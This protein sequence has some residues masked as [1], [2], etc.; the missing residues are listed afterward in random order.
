[1]DV[2]VDEAAAVGRRQR[3]VA[4]AARRLAVLALAGRQ[5]APL[6]AVGRQADDLE[7]AVGVGRV[8]PA[9]VGHRR[10]APLAHSSPPPAT[11]RSSPVSTSIEVDL[12]DASGPGPRIASTAIVRP[13]ADQLEV[14]DV[15]ARSPISGRGSGGR[16]SRAGRPR[17][18]HRRIDDPDLRPAAAPRDE[19]EAPAVGRPARRRDAG[20]MAGDPDVAR[21]VGL[22]DPDLVVADVGEAAA[23]GRPLRVGDVL[24]RRGELDGVAA[25]QRQ[26]EELAGAGRVRRV[27]D[28]AVA[29]MEPE[30][31]RRLDRDDLLDRQAAPRRSRPARRC[32]LVAAV[33]PSAAHGR[34]QPSRA[35]NGPIIARWP[36]TWP[37]RSS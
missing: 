34:G 16:G 8:E 29:R 3:R 26:D 14:L 30:L 25:A 10:A 5:D 6:A 19:R 18:G 7:P 20:R 21:P 11:R 9:A 15:D 36:R 22:D 4:R 2:D 23:V 32:R 31:A 27:G 17:R 1:M 12:A 37:W 35:A 33:A 24:L 28:E 13:S